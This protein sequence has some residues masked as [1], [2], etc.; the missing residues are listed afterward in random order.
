DAAVDETSSLPADERMVNTALARNLPV[1]PLRPLRIFEQRLN[2]AALVLGRSVSA[3]RVVRAASVEN[4]R[5]LRAFPVQQ[6]MHIRFDSLRLDRARRA[7]TMKP[8][9]EVV[10]RSVSEHDDRREHRAVLH[11]LRVLS[12]ELLVV[13]AHLCCTFSDDRCETYLH[14]PFSTTA[15]HIAQNTSPSIRS[16]ITYFSILSPPVEA[17][18]QAVSVPLHM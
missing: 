6:F 4:G 3:V 16:V 17:I 18:R 13:A 7:D 10:L 8:V 11:R 1:R 2:G 14:R 15:R 12:D 5:P 9:R